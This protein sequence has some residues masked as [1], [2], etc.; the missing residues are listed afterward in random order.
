[1]KIK[2]LIK[3]LDESVNGYLM[4]N[5]IFIFLVLLISILFSVNPL[6]YDL[7]FYINIMVGGYGL[8]LLYSQ[9]KKEK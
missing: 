3:I 1:M 7:G 9:Y 5:G 6:E 4:I 2:K 8:F